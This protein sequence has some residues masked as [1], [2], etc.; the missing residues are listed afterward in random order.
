MIPA[1][2]WAIHII[3]KFKHGFDPAYCF[4]FD[5]P[6]K[7]TDIILEVKI[8]LYF[9]HLL[10][11]GTSISFDLASFF[12]FTLFQGWIRPSVLSIGGFAKAKHSLF[13]VDDF[14]FGE[15]LLSIRIHPSS[16]HIHWEV[17]LAKVDYQNLEKF[18]YC[19]IHDRC[20]HLFFKL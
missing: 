15:R 13:P 4:E 8:S 17:S 12:V 11:L 5:I 2:H 9:A 1:A 6:I 16:F 18:Y 20:S 7:D 14:T 3:S 10:G 19:L